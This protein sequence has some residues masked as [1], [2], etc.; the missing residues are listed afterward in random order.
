MDIRD[1]VM[2]SKGNIQAAEKDLSNI[3]RKFPD[4]QLIMAVLP[5][6]KELY[7]RY[8][9]F[10]WITVIIIVINTTII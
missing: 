5:R 3:K 9:I 4:I 8:I 6:N 2:I 7:G 10:I 1:P